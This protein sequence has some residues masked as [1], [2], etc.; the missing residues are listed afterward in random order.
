MVR[1]GD[2]VLKYVRVDEG[3]GGESNYDEN[4]WTPA[5]GNAH[6]RPNAYY[7]LSFGLRDSSTNQPKA[8]GERWGARCAQRPRAQR[9]TAPA[10]RARR[11]QLL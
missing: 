8:K 7:A 1:N 9:L 3:N 6:G 2:T 5:L 10:P 11:A 4:T